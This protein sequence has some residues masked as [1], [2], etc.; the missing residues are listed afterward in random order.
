VDLNICGDATL[1]RIKKGDVYQHDHN[2]FHCRAL[3]LRLA[4]KAN[5]KLRG[6]AKEPRIC[7][8][9]LTQPFC[10]DYKTLGLNVEEFV[11]EPRILRVIISPLNITTKRS[12]TLPAQS[13]YCVSFF[14]ICGVQ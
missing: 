4:E 8:G 12:H 2:T 13:F 6:S 3:L 1:V 14:T 7:G 11:V 9:W 10:V 5:D